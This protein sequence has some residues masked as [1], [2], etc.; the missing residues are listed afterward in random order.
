MN[1][2][3][4]HFTDM[5]MIFTGV[6]AAVISAALFTKFRNIKDD[7]SGKGNMLI[8]ALGSLFVYLV[9]DIPA[10]S[11]MCR[12]GK[13]MYEALSFVSAANFL[14][15]LAVID[16]RHRVIP[17]LYVA[18]AFA[19]K[20]VM[21]IVSGCM[22]H[23]LPEMFA[24]SFAGMAAASVI[25]GAAYIVSGKGIGAGD[26]KM[27]AAAGYIT[28][29]FAVTDIIMY[30]TFLCALCGILLVSAKKC[31]IRDCIPMAPFAYA[32]TLICMIT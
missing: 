20:T 10:L 16:I 8:W 9:T 5:N 17:N 14:F 3:K 28:G 12:N 11:V 13:N 26:V 7:D 24:G 31:R 1:T 2:E 32:G 27:F 25:T 29:G 23:S 6:T 18:V 21:I 30:S 15:L 22:M 19:V 4:G